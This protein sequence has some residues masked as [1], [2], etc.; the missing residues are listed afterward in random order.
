MDK[1]KHDILTYNGIIWTDWQKTGFS[2]K[3]VINWGI[4]T[5]D[6]HTTKLDLGFEYTNVKYLE[7]AGEFEVDGRPM[8]QQELLLCV[9][10]LAN[11]VVPLEWYKS[12]VVRF[13]ITYLNNTS[14]YVERFNDPTSGKAIP[15]EIIAKRVSARQIIDLVDIAETLERLEELRVLAL[16]TVGDCD[17]CGNNK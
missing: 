1:E 13:C 12:V 17:S 15:E 8:T 6:A 7:Q 9:Q 2:Q 4:F 3:E 11:I 10:F 5:R 14:W 16:E